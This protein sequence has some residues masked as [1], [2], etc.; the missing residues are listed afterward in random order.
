M[1][2]V[3]CFLAVPSGG[4]P[5]NLSDLQFLHLLNWV[6]IYLRCHVSGSS[7]CKVPRMQC[8]LSR[9]C[10]VTS[11]ILLKGKDMEGVVSFC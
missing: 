11:Y 8:V 3:C 1:E 10:K 6:K 2:L 9:C 7:L 5:S 4:K